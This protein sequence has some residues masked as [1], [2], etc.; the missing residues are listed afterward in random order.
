[1]SFLGKS[2]NAAIA[3]FRKFIKTATVPVVVFAMAFS[4]LVPYARELKTLRQEGKTLTQIV[5]HLATAYQ[6]ETTPGTLSRFFKANAPQLAPR[7]LTQ[8]EEQRFEA[9]ALLTEVLVEVR[10]RSEEERLAIEHLAGQVAVN[11]ASLAELEQRIASQ[12]PIPRTPKAATEALAA[13]TLRRIWTRAAL[14]IAPIAGAV[15]YLLGRL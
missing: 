9:V 3:F 11:T 1:M 14:V 15:G 7:E 12:S 10:A 13:D 8:A 5:D 6:V 2:G 4:N